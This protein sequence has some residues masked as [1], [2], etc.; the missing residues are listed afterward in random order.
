MQYEFT[1]SGITPLLLHAD[2]VLWADRLKEWRS[3]PD[4]KGLS[5]KGDDRSPA[6]TWLG[7]VPTESETLSLPSEYLTACLRQAGGKVSTGKGQETFKKLTQ[8]A[9][10]FNEPAIPI[11]V[12]KDREQKSFKALK[13][14]LD[15]ELKFPVH[16]KAVESFGFKLDVRRAGVNGKSKHVRVRPCIEKWAL[17]GTLEVMDDDVL[18]EKTLATIFSIG[19]KLGLGDWRPGGK[20]PGTW[21]QYTVEIMPSDEKKAKKGK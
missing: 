11:L 5:T 13:D 16:L 18:N 6:W 4:N 10:W 3:D 15:G 20:T 7:S 9:I 14:Q 1:V 21:G 19:G 2:N 8:S 17:K 12:G